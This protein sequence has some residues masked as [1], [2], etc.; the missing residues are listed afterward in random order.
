M[1]PNVSFYQPRVRTPSLLLPNRHPQAG[2]GF[3]K[4]MLN[5]GQDLG[6]DHVEDDESDDESVEDV[7]SPVRKMYNEDGTPVTYTKAEQNAFDSANLLIE[8]EV[9]RCV[10]MCVFVYVCV[11]I[12]MYLFIFKSL[13]N[14]FF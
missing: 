14:F 11:Y 5:G 4:S 3:R 6:P 13:L 9:D 2:L 10:C 12:C 7:M 1:I 8:I